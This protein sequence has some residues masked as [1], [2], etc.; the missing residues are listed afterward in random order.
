MTV[1]AQ[2]STITRTYRAAIK[3]GDDFVTIEETVTLS[4]NASDTD[5]AAAV[6]TGLR[7]FTAQA[8]AVEAQIAA[9]RGFHP[10][11]AGAT[12]PATESQLSYLET[13]V[14]RGTGKTLAAYVAEKGTTLPLT[15]SGASGL[16]EELKAG[17]QTPAAVAPTTPHE[18]VEEDLHEVREESEPTEAPIAP[19]DTAPATDRQINAIRGI[20]A[21]KKLRLVDVL[22]THVGNVPLEQLTKGQAGIVIGALQKPA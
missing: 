8:A 1:P 16:I 17:V 22:K 11:G 12:E 18:H 10:V 20:C 5:I 4:T 19:T 9:L 3:A 21:G 13:L 6:A 7:I 15:K 14:G 2:S